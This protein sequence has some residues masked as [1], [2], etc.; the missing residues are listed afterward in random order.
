MCAAL[1]S[2]TPD[3]TSMARTLTAVSDSASPAPVAFSA[4]LAVS[5]GERCL[6]PEVHEIC[7]TSQ[8][9]LLEGLFVAVANRTSVPLLALR[10]IIENLVHA[11]FRGVVVTI[12]ENGRL[13]RCSDSGPG[14]PDPDRALQEGYTSATEADR[15]LIRGVG[16]GL[17]L[18]TRAM[19]EVGGILALDENLGGGSVL[20]LH[21]PG[22][23]AHAPASDTPERAQAA[24]AL[25]LEMGS[26]GPAELAD[27][28]GR[29]LA[30]CG[31]DLVLLEHRGL[32]V[33]ESNG[34]RRLTESGAAMIAAH[35]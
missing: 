8:A 33:R 27:E 30:H 12:L 9:E 24:L 15:Q 3:E 7:A 6:P 35:F 34:N 31:R 11:R 5:A 19:D 25:L 18:A 21:A 2:L 23:A 10:E 22:A 26:A 20:A 29:P 32:V 1:H 16:C 14:I 28:L 13:V 17:P 4:Q